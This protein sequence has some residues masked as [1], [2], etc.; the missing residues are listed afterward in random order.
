MFLEKSKAFLCRKIKMFF[1]GK[2]H[3]IT[4]K[5]VLNCVISKNKF[6]FK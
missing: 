3:I 2:L 6:A 5:I 1:V 4:Q